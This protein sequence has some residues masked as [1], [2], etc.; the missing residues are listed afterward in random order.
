MRAHMRHLVAALLFGLLMVNAQS[1]ADGP[2]IAGVETVIRAQIDAFRSDDGI[3]AFGLASPS[4]QHQFGDPE[5]FLRMV[6]AAYPAVYRPKRLVFLDAKTDGAGRPVQKVLIEGMDG[7][8]VIALYPMVRV[9]K[10]WRIDG[11][12]LMKPGGKKI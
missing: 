7:T 6:R 3:A 5:T 8:T 9:N 11:C 10:R 12:V 4:I 1:R 2:A